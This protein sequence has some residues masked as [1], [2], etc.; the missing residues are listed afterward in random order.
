MKEMRP[1]GSREMCWEEIH[2]EWKQKRQN[3]GRG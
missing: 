1:E 2:T 3:R